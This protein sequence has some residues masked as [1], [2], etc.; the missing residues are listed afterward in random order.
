MARSTKSGAY[1][2]LQ[3]NIERGQDPACNCQGLTKVIS[4][5]PAEVTLLYIK[6]RASQD[7]QHSTGTLLTNAR[8]FTFHHTKTNT[9]SS[10]VK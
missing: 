7:L 5:A 1:P 10:L 3:G 2:T 6:C 8:V 9:A 4:F